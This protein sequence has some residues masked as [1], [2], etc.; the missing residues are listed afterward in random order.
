MAEH[1][2]ASYHINIG[3]GDSAIHV[4][5]K[6]TTGGGPKEYLRAVLVDGG[7]QAASTVLKSAIELI[8]KNYL[9]DGI[10]KFDSIVVTHWDMDH[11][12]GIVKLL[13]DDF[14]NQLKVNKELDKKKLRSTY[15]KYD[16]DGSGCLTTFYAPYWEPNWKPSAIGGEN[17]RHESLRENEN[18]PIVLL[19]IQPKKGADWVLGVCKLCCWPEGGSGYL[20][21]ELFTNL[22]CGQDTIANPKD[23]RAA[24]GLLD[25]AEKSLPGLFCIGGD[26]LEIGKRGN[27]FE[28]ESVGGAAA[29][30]LRGAGNSSST[31]VLVRTQ[32]FSWI[33]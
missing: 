5:E 23:L 6:P 3:T 10:I 1:S 28:R 33:C 8:S 21:R 29:G 4:L 20:R 13:K 22:D 12:G 19:D 2:V 27:T 31:L 11:F 24:Y 15:M 7:L 26:G 9:K 32:L 30:N 18:G 25:G 16:K 17:M 14:V